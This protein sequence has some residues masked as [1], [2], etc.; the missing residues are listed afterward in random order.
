MST[1]ELICILAPVLIGGG[2]LLHASWRRA[3]RQIKFERG[4]KLNVIHPKRR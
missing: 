4:D 1:L 2:I 3:G